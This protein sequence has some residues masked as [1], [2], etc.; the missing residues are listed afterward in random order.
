MLHFLLSNCRFW[1][2]EYRFDGFRFDGI[3]SMLYYDH[4]LEKAFTSYENYFSENV[5]EDALTYLA[6]ANKV[7]HHIKPQAIT[8]AEDISGM[9]GLAS[10]V[11]KGGIGF[12]YRLAMGLPDLPSSHIRSATSSVIGTLR[13]PSSCCARACFS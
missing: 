4:G 7:I 5:D 11:N 10:P 9:P 3:T 6:L 8:I 2:D 12:D 1:L 13:L